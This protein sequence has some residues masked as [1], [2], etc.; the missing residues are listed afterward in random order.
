MN[1]IQ[2]RP[3]SEFPEEFDKPVLVYYRRLVGRLKDQCFWSMIIRNE[4]DDFL[5]FESQDWIDTNRVRLLGWADIPEEDVE[6][7]TRA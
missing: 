2:I 5:W 7:L 6:Y 1:K 4:D 3:M